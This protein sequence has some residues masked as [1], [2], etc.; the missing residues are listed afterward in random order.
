MKMKIQT[1]HQMKNPS[2]KKMLSIMEHDFLKE[3]DRWKKKCSFFFLPTKSLLSLSRFKFSVEDTTSTPIICLVSL[4]R[5]E[6]IKILLFSFI[7]FGTS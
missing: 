2:C 1:L 6:L 5:R 7:I 3:R 4:H